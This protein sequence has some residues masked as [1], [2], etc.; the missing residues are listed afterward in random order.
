MACGEAMAV[1]GVGCAPTLRRRL[2]LRSESKNGGAGQILRR[3]HPDSMLFRGPL[4]VG[5]FRGSYAIVFSRRFDPCAPT[6]FPDTAS[7]YDELFLRVGTKYLDSG[8]FTWRKPANESRSVEMRKE[9]P[10]IAEIDEYAER[11]VKMYNSG[12]RDV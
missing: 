7:S 11:R 5:T 3:R 10:L 1:T 4:A 12:Y 8:D 9:D 6:G 2:C